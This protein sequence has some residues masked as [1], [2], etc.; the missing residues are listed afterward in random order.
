MD[1][2]GNHMNFL[3]SAHGGALFSVAEAAVREACG[4]DDAQLIDAHLTLTA[5]APAGDRFVAVAEPVNV[6]R[7][8]AVYR[9]SVT[10]G[11]GRV[12][13]VFTATV[14]LGA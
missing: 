5:G 9:A 14:R 10:R 3:D 6:G 7:T 4:R 13:G 1:L 2:T 8:L 12:C 11:D